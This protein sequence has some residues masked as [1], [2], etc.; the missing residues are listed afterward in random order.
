MRTHVD[1]ITVKDLMLARKIAAAL[2]SKDERGVY[3][4]YEVTIYPRYDNNG[5]AVNPE[6]EFSLDIFK[7]E[8]LAND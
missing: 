5:R 2:E 3:P 4:E 1:R 8:D 7:K 6:C